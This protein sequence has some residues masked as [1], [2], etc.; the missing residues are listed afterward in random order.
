MKANTRN[1]LLNFTGYVLAVVT[2]FLGIAIF[3]LLLERKE[4]IMLDNQQNYTAIEKAPFF[5]QPPDNEPDIAG[6]AQN[7]YSDL[8]ARLSIWEINN[9]VN[10][11][12][13]TTRE[14]FESELSMEQAVLKAKEETRALIQIQAIPPLDVDKFMLDTARLLSKK[15]A[16]EEAGRWSIVFVN[17]NDGKDYQVLLDALTGKILSITSPFEQRAHDI[18]KQ[19][20]L[21]KFSIYHNLFTADMD[22]TYVKEGASKAYLNIG[23]IVILC[24]NV[25]NIEDSSLNR[26]TIGL[27]IRTKE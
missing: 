17:A 10:S 23:D 21:I 15:R 2:V 5:I 18:S 13:M 25:V 26:F 16:S 9:E 8:L 19:E 27:E 1:I 22:M 24:Q 4:S 12:M 6:S 7:N 11:G 20:M 3:N 14:P